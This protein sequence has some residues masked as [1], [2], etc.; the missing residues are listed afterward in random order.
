MDSHPDIVVDKKSD[1][2][3]ED[4]TAHDSKLLIPTLK[5]FFEKHPLINPKV[6]LGDAA[7][8]SVTIYEQLLSGDTFG[9]NKHF[10]QA[11]IPLNERSKLKN[12]DFTINENGIPCCPHDPSL[13]Q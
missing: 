8:D 12:P 5:D 13:Y 6:F 7:F 10:R 3:D 9:K 1:S 11:F 2:P 4:K